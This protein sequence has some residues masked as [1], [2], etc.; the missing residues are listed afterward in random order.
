MECSKNIQKFN[1]KRSLTESD[2]GTKLGNN[3]FK[4]FSVSKNNND[5]VEIP[6]KE[7]SLQEI[8]LVQFMIFLKN[9]FSKMVMQNTKK[10]YQ[11]YLKNVLALFNVCQK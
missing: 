3:F 10:S 9:L 5:I 4:N 1:C 11:R 6:L 2:D 8:L 7:Q